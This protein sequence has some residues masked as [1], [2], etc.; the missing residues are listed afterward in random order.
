MEIN[1]V[2]TLNDNYAK[3][4]AALIRSILINK[5]GAYKINFHVV[6][7]DL[8]SFSKAA[9]IN[10]IDDETC[11]TLTTY[12]Y[13][14]VEISNTFSLNKSSY[15]SHIS[16]DTFVRLF[17]SQIIPSTID[18]VLYLDVDIIVNG[19]VADLF[20]D[21]DIE[22]YLAGAVPQIDEYFLENNERVYSSKS[23]YFNAGVL[24]LNLKKMRTINVISI[25][26]DFYSKNSN[27][28]IYND[29][30][31]LNYCIGYNVKYL[32]LK[33]NV[34]TPYLRK[35]AREYLDKKYHCYQNSYNSADFYTDTINNPVIIH[36][37]SRPK[38]WEFGC[39]HPYRELYQKALRL[40]SFP[41]NENKVKSIISNVFIWFKLFY[42]RFFHYRN[43]FVKV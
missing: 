33:Y 17:L 9:M 24:L 38:P 36:F 30:D 39:T 29:Q 27:L 34:I 7:N 4:C 35:G 15:L 1:I 42:N 22:N 40:T 41:S 14:S 26:K 19:D 28:V 11:A 2:F 25:Y 20:L 12:V 5:R 31:I 18:I 32:D 43:S 16:T 3:H 13:D 6:S 10:V 21:Y 8:S 23:F 37:V